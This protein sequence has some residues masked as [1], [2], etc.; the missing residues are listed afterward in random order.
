MVCT[1]ARPAISGHAY[2]CCKRCPTEYITLGTIFC[3]ACVSFEHAPEL[4]RQRII[5]HAF[6]SIRLIFPLLSLIPT[7][8]IASDN[9]VHDNGDAGIALLEV[10]DAEISHNNIKDNYYGMRLSV[11]CGDNFIYDNEFHDSKK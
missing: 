4:L 2:T 5:T 10:F 8:S 7:T 9:Y 11:G 1:Q 3:S 6:L